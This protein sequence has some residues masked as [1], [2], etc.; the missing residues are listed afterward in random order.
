[1]NGT[2]EADLKAI[3]KQFKC[4]VVNTHFSRHQL[5]DIS[6]VDAG[7]S[8]ISETNQLIDG[9]CERLENGGLLFV[10]GLP[11]V[12]PFVANHLNN[13]SSENYK[14]L[15]KYWIAL[16]LK[17]FFFD[18]NSSLLPNSHLGLLMYLKTK[19]IENPTPF[20]L[21]TKTVRIPYSKCPACNQITKDWGGKKHLMNSLGSAIS[22]VW[23]ECDCKME[24]SER[25][26][27]RVVERIRD[28]AGGTD[29]TFILVNQE[30][31]RS[32]STGVGKQLLN[33]K[34]GYTLKLSPDD[35]NRVIHGD[36]LSF[37]D[38][39]AKDNPKGVFDLAFADP[40]YNLAKNY[41][42]YGDEQ[43]DSKYL[44]WCD[45]WL[46]GMSKVIKP[47]GALLILNIPKWSV[48]HYVTLASELN[49]RNWIVW[50]ALSTP[51]GKLLPAHY[52]LLYFTK[53]GAEP[54]SNY[55][56]FSTI[57]N[58]KYCLRN[59]CMKTRKL[60]GDNEK[61]LLSDVWKDVHRI[62]HKKDRDHHP[63]QLPLKLM[64][65]ILK[66]FTNEGDLVFDPFGGA[67]T[68]A[69]AAKIAKRNFI[70][71][72]MDVN[73]VK[74]AKENLNKISENIYGELMFNRPASNNNSR[75]PINGGISRKAV[76]QMFIRL[77]EENNKVL[78]A[79][80]IKNLDY[81]TYKF[82][83]NYAGDFKKLQNIGKRNLETKLFLK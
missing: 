80:E 55:K 37:M 21:N 15:F 56:D 26:P 66:L 44:E 5:R 82:V 1:M 47:G 43:T 81:S 32:S 68:T 83:A 39:I 18:D 2:S 54:K 33:S 8:Y 28:L 23:S 41:S 19:S 4:I 20:H 22:D 76:E 51:M 16:E 34:R 57:E 60:L 75:K 79:E 53:P 74:I 24:D 67:G 59:S 31:N 65:R 70:I 27:K 38:N 17:P 49:F 12:L 6:L 9:C 40:P 58:R 42:T 35:I 30:S 52:S 10:Y 62:K 3:Q 7:N 69:V 71:T 29:E 13:L 36:C 63:C 77:C 11:K 50:D 46:R 25:I 45:Q 48:E 73:Y 14:F 78:S 61:E 64:E 72:E